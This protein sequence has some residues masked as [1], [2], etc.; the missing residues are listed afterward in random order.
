MSAA[1]EILVGAV[2]VVGLVG[3]L[4]PVLPGLALV[5]AAVLVWAMVVQSTVGW[6]VLAGASALLVVGTVV[7]YVV[8]GRRLRRVGV[9]WRSTALG[10]A[11]AVVGFFVIPVVGLL[12]GFVL[13]VYLAERQRLGAHTAAWQSTRQA[14][15][16]AGWSV[17]IE[18]FAGMAMAGTWLAGVLVG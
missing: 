9:P 13:G 17:L 14:L 2:I 11:L 8:P 15:A 16:A 5:W 7:K 10:G 4:V 6:A 18:L 3:V 12:I 1:G